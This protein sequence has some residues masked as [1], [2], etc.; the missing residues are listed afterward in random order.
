[1]TFAPGGVWGTNLFVLSSTTGE[2]TELLADGSKRTIGSGFDND[3]VDMRFGPD[4]ALYV[5]EYAADRVLRI[6]PSRETKGL[7]RSP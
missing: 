4:Q 1:M 5:S 6:A 7:D 3:P 2:L